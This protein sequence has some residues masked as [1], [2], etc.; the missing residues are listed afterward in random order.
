LPEPQLRV[1]RAEL[2]AG[3]LRKIAGI[4]EIDDGYALRF[5]AEPGIAE[6]LGLFIEYERACCGFLDFTLRVKNTSGPIVLELTGPGRTKESLRSMLDG[7][8]K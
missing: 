2:S 7:F 8:R 5:A 1:R 4:E 6:E 3:L